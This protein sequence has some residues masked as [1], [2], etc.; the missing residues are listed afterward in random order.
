MKFIILSV[1]TYMSIGLICCT[2]KK[3]T[4]MKIVH[5]TQE[6]DP[7]SLSLCEKTRMS[8]DMILPT[9][10]QG[11]DSLM[12]VYKVSSLQAFSDDDEEEV[13][14]DERYINI[15]IPYAFNDLTKRG[16]VPV[17]SALYNKKLEDLGLASEQRHKLPY[18]Y[19]YKHYFSSPTIMQGWTDD[20]AEDGIDKKDLRPNIFIT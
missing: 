20:M 19:E 14:I 1:L 12:R 18:V 7:M 15:L 13:R 4:E 2:N 10:S 11:M 16:F 17:S 3:G 6:K 9:D 5:T 8:E